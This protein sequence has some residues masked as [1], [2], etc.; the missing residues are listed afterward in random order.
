[1]QYKSNRQLVVSDW[2]RGC[3]CKRYPLMLIVDFLN[4]LVY[5]CQ[6][7]FILIKPLSILS[8]ILYIIY[9]IYLSPQNI[10]LRCYLYKNC[11]FQTILKI[12]R[13]SKIHKYVSASFKFYNKF[14]KF[15]LFLF[16]DFPGCCSLQKHVMS[17]V[18]SSDIR[19]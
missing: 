11:Q 1:M 5:F 4:S 14:G 9:H 10:F 19:N 12:S 18:W 3:W 7:I 15:N 6:I 8:Y 16:L 2:R 13:C 17:V